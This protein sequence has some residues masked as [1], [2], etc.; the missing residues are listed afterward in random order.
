MKIT[1]S[2]EPK[3][4]CGPFRP[5]HG[6]NKG[7]G[8]TPRV[9]DVLALFRRVRIPVVRLHDC[10]GPTFAAVDHHAVFPDPTADPSD[11]RSYDFNRTDAYLADVCNAGCDIMYRL[12]E[13]IEHA[14]IK[15]RVNPPPDLDRWARVCIG[16]I[17]HYNDGWA[18]GYRYGIRQWEIWNEPDNKPP[19]WTGTDE[20]FFALYAVASSRIKCEFPDLKVG[21]CG[22]G[23]VG[24]VVDGVL[25][26]NEFLAGFID[27][28]RR[29]NLPLD[30]FSW[31]TY[32]DDAGA[33]VELASAI[34]GF[35]NTQGYGAAESHL[36][37]W[38]Y[39]ADNRWAPFLP[40][41]SPAEKRQFFER[42][43]GSEGGAFVA[44]T[45]MA[46]Q[47][48]PV[49]VANY[50]D[51]GCGGFGLFESDGKPRPAYA[52]FE[53]LHAMLDCSAR[54]NTRIQPVC[55][56]RAAAGR[57]QDGRLR[58]WIANPTQWACDLTVRDADGRELGSFTVPP[59]GVD[60]R[61][62]G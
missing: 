1:V 16:I 41:S 47:D 21:G 4:R 19:M 7:P 36:N 18:N 23:T 28:V 51:A 2:I 45:L 33:V 50:Y 24:T 55:G 53:A 32:S 3:V 25:K 29:G 59:Y 39:L 56:V 26:P 60:C 40:E 62:L 49:E 10:V 14:P 13:S 54:L 9:R 17:R 35:L 44:A 57:C 11:P 58:V 12:G 37:E 48:A 22:F 20:E 27:A 43:G 5:L 38:N 6:V 46:L 42:L 30:F 8:E 15:T 52:A 31:H 61:G 34:R